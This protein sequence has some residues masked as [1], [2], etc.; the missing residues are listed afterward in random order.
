MLLSSLSSSFF[1]NP[2]PSVLGNERFTKEYKGKKGEEGNERK[3]TFMPTTI[4]ALTI[5]NLCNGCIAAKRLAFPP[6]T[7]FLF[8]FYFL[9]VFPLIFR[10]FSFIPIYSAFMFFSFL[11]TFIFRVGSAVTFDWAGNRLENCCRVSF[12]SF[13]SAARGTPGF[14]AV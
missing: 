7:I 4:S 8:P 11:N 2:W 5:Y 12:F 13:K 10:V 6:S 1:P 14:C 3:N 9:F